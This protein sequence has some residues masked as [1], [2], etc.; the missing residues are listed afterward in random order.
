[1]RHN[2]DLFIIFFFDV[3][4]VKGHVSFCRSHFFTSSFS[5][6]PLSEELKLASHTSQVTPLLQVRQLVLMKGL[7]HG[8]DLLPAVTSSSLRRL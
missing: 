2:A 5:L 8:Q 6:S 3:K 4:E 7:W 1:M